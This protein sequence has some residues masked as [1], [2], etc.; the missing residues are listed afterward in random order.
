MCT[1]W[2]T[3][4]D[5]Q[6]R[7]CHVCW[8]CKR[9]RVKDWVGRCIAE[10]ELCA[11]TTCVTLTY[12]KSDRLYEIDHPHAS[13]LV[14]VDVQKYLKML[15]L[16]TDSRVRFFCTGEYG[17]RKGRAHWHLILFFCCGEMTP[18]VKFEERFIHSVGNQLIW[19]HGWSFW[20]VADYEKMRY[21]VKY[22]LKDVF[23]GKERVHRSSKMPEIGHYYFKRLAMQAAEAQIPPRDVYRFP[24]DHDRRGKPREYR[25]TR[26][27]LYKYLAHYAYFYK[28]LH[29]DENWPRSD[30]MD[31]FV[32][33]R[34]RRARRSVGEADYSESD[35]VRRFELERRE[36]TLK[37]TFMTK[38]DDGG[39]PILHPPPAVD[40]NQYR[41]VSKGE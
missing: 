15:R 38:D 5:G 29:G 1:N 6:L 26:A 17:S 19:P 27:A 23:E 9:D 20:Q 14:Y 24:N 10:S 22:I 3:M 33:E 40:L 4:P 2:I 39:D 12:G 18:G 28:E 30:L 25:L 16:N 13:K 21:A 31:A 32:D 36:R 41:K 11:A 34:A 37:W 7:P 8:Q 35:F